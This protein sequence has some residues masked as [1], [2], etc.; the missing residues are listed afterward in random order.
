MPMKYLLAALMVFV[1]ITV[2]AGGLWMDYRCT[3]D[4]PLG[5]RE[6]VYF[7]IGKG[8]SLSAITQAL[9]ARGL[10]EKPYWFRLLALAEKAQTRLKYGEYEIPANTTPRQLL[11]MFA[12]GKVRHYSLTFVEG[13]NFRQ[14]VEAL[15][16]QADLTHHIDG[17]SPAEVMGL[18]DAPGEDAEGRFF[19]DTY[20]Y[21][22]GTSDLEL[23]R[24]AYRKMQAV[25][26]EEWQGRAEG[27]SLH[28][29]Y[30]ALI[31]ASIVEKETGVVDERSRIAGVFNRRLAKGMPLQ[32]DPTVIYG[33]GVA[34]AGNIGAEDLLRDTPYNTYVHPGLPPTPIAMPGLQAIHA[35][36]HPDMGESLYFVAR[37]DGTHVF[38]NTLAEHN[39]AVD[40]YQKNRHE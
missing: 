4:A 38:S 30:E 15:S 39:K 3:I 24:R 16:R 25:L 11:T 1:V 28:A 6:T 21:T 32:T 7:E 29:P 37:G 18:I 10:I 23:L 9:Q 31:L 17:K 19:P 14:I 12:T 33:M 20:F 40:Q 22:K 27:L 13:W 2:V 34:Y 36:L 5:N 35:A 8:Q 26:A